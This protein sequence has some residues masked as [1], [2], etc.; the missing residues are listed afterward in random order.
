MDVS[1]RYRESWESYWRRTPQAPGAAIFDCDAELSA[2]RHLPLLAPYADAALPVIDLGCGT[3]TQTRYLARHFREAVGVDLA[4][5][6]VA[7][8]RRADPGRTARYE[9][10]N[11]TDQDAVRRLHERVGDANVYMRA[12]IHQ[13]EPEARPAVAAAVA[14]LTGTRGRAFVVELLSRAKAVLAHAAQG[15]D[16]P[17]PKLARIF[18]HG[19][20]PAEADDDAVPGFFRE[21]GL[22][23]LASGEIDLVMTENRADGVRID[24]PAQWMVLGR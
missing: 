21:L 18:E 1:Q 13:S 6:A 4:E 20:T 7:H 5:A 12:V 3:G 17:P 24:L 11:L 15:P 2:A 16:G 10:L 14:T 19:L 8:A 22:P 23:V 9:Q